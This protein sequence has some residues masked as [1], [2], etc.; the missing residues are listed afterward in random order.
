MLPLCLFALAA[1][2]DAASPDATADERP[3]ITSIAVGLGGSILL[4][5]NASGYADSLAER[6][7]FDLATGDLVCFSLEF[8]HAR[9]P[10]TD[11]GAYFPEAPV[12]AGALSGFRDYYALDAG[13]RLGVPVGTRD[14]NRVR[15][16]PYLRVGVAL[17]LTS[18]LLDTPSLDGR[19]ALRSNTAWPAPSLGAGVELR[20]RRWISLLPH[21]KTQV[22]VF[23]DT[24]EDLG[25]PT[26]VA[27]EWRFQ[28][29]LDVSIHF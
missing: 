13:F 1:A 12:P 2:S 21:L 18:T 6:V 25:G 27:A 11:S 26:R 20:I 3:R 16:L 24:A 28:P 19:I 8:D 22:Q 7:V 10:L 17:A 5:D 9:H 4:G 14:P 29:A 15:A 23:E